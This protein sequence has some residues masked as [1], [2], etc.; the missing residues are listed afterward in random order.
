MIGYSVPDE[1]EEI[2]ALFT[3]ALGSKREH[4]K[5]RVAQLNEDARVN[6][7]SFSMTGPCDT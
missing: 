5:I 6:Y 4:P 1:D 2:R 7:E 3:R